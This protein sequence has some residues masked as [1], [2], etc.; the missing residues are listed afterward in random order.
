MDTI[1]DTT[2]NA[3]DYAADLTVQL[4]KGILTQCVLL[5]AEHP[6]YTSE[7]LAKLESAELDIVEGTIYPLLSRLSREGLLAHEWQE[8]KGGPPRKY[9]QITDYGQA[10]RAHLTTSIKKLN[11]VIKQLER[12]SL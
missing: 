2:E 7:L 6:F 1:L 3:A 10:V 12:S 11:K 5:T 9:Y 8:S 4:K